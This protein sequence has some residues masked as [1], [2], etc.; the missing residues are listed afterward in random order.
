MNC[1]GLPLRLSVAAFESSAHQIY[2]LSWVGMGL[3]LFDSA[4]LIDLGLILFKI[5]FAIQLR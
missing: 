4:K 1:G 2:L 5:V 3:L